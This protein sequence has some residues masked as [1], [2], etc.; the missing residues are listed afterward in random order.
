MADEVE[1]EDWNDLRVA[2]L[3]EELKARG[4]DAT[5]PKPD[6]VARLEESDLAAEM[7]QADEYNNDDPDEET[8]DETPDPPVEPASGQENA[9]Q[10]I[11]E[12][13]PSPDLG[14]TVFV[15][16]VPLPEDIDNADEIEDED[17]QE[18][19][20]EARAQAEAAGHSPIGGAFSAKMTG[21]ANGYVTYEVPLR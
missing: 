13:E 19:L 20:L 21:S 7:E 2:E 17:A 16:E 8:P 5:G 4:L 1:V 15:A 18:M 12:P 3:R 9:V 10:A 11:N 14:P 6:L